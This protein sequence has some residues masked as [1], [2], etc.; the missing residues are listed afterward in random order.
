MSLPGKCSGTCFSRE[1]C[2]GVTRHLLALTLEVWAESAS[3]TVGLKA[4]S[5]L[6]IGHM[7]PVGLG[8]VAM[9]K[10]MCGD[11]E[12]AHHNGTAVMTERVWSK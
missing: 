4:K 1:A 11:G 9:E 3:W 2:I 10:R 5:P 7:D 12:G 6:F 8:A